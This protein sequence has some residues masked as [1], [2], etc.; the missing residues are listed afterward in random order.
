MLVVAI[1]VMVLSQV[2]FIVFCISIAQLRREQL[3]I[4]QE[5]EERYRNIHNTYSTSWLDES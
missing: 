5:F 1:L 4:Q 2:V 3:K